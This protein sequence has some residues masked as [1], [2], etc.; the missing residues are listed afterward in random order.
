MEGAARRLALVGTPLELEGTKLD[1]T[2]L[3]WKAY[4]GKVVLVQFW[5]SA[6][7]DF[8]ALLARTRAGL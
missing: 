6:A 5:T 7:S 1:G 8:P 3:D 2:P 4:R